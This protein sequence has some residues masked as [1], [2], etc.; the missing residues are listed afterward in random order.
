[1]NCK[2]KEYGEKHTMRVSAWVRLASLVASASAA[3]CS[4]SPPPPPSLVTV[5]C[6]LMAPK[7]TAPI[8]TN[9]IQ[10]GCGP[11]DY[12]SNTQDASPP[13]G[14]RECIL[15]SD[16]PATQCQKACS[17]LPTDMEYSSQGCIGTV[18]TGHA[19]E[20]CLTAT[21]SAKALALPLFNSAGT[22]DVTLAGGGTVSFGGA[23]NAA[24]VTEGVLNLTA[25]KTSCSAA[26][27]SCVVQFNLVRLVF[28]DFPLNGHTISQLTVVNDGPTLTAP[29]QFDPSS[30]LF[31]FTIPAGTLFDA[32]GEIDGTS[33][34]LQVA[35]TIDVPGSL[36][37]V[38]GATTFQFQFSGQF[39]GSTFGA[40]GTVMQSQVIDVAP[41]LTAPQSVS[42]SATTSCAA[43]VT[44]AATA[45]SA[46]GLPVTIE[47]AIDGTPVGSGASVTTTLPIGAH[48]A[49]VVATDADGEDALAVVPVTVSDETAPVFGSVPPSVTVQSCSS[50]ASPIAVTVP[51][52]TDACSGAAAT[53]TGTVVSFNGATESIP[54]VNGTVS[55]PSGSGTLQFVARNANGVTSTVSEALTV[56][57][58]ATFYGL[59]GVAIDD[60]ATV[61]G[62]VYSG[63][64]GVASVGND[65]SVTSVVS[66]SP[67]LLHDRTTVS[68]IDTSAGVTRGNGDHVGSVSTATPVL[69]AFPPVSV[70]FTG[71]QTVTVNPSPESG[72]VVSLSPGQYGAVTVSSRGKLVLSAGNYEFRSLNLES[73]GQIVVPSSSSEAVRVFVQNAV[74]YQG[75]AVTSS[76]ALAP[77]YLAYTGSAP[78]TLESPPFDGTIL[79]PNATL[80]LESLNGSGVYTGE[81]FA[82]Q[83]T[84]APHTVTNSDP[85]S[86]P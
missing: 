19:S 53:V 41:T 4:N 12:T 62:T 31:L 20:S 48:Q 1:M 36:N 63:A 83:I 45:T 46:A 84:L 76:G 28:G 25:P 15:A 33:T 44:L 2:Y 8:V 69:P 32:V 39:A 43:S 71:T 78:L 27:D 26:D 6:D 35:S 59:A 7:C 47:Y 57:A 54:V 51:G 9:G 65:A 82:Q 61:N 68:V 30:G 58:P 23:S 42:A 17:Q 55:V 22:M 70:T 13:G 80:T 85:F 24:P 11:N 5:Y 86:C 72:D 38:T 52:A 74:T 75:S 50:G 34:G 77:L 66:L 29:G 60:G 64:G 67:V 10:T 18:D 16:D 21:L 37:P 81:F 49:V 79:A 73:Q 3:A 40:M 14:M 56:Q